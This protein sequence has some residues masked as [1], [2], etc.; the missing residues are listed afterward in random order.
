M[1]QKYL[2]DEFGQ[3]GDNLDERLKEFN[4]R[5]LA[6]RMILRDSES[7]LTEIFVAAQ[8][9]FEALADAELDSRIL[10]APNIPK[11]VAQTRR[12][13]FLEAFERVL[14]DFDEIQT[15]AL[16]VEDDIADEEE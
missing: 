2:S 6:W 11:A 14:D 16:D 9:R 3:W 5:M 4:S 7:D 13:I 8:R 15:V 12:G 1:S 10:S